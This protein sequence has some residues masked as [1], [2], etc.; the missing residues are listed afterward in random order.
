[1]SLCRSRFHKKR[2]KSDQNCNLEVNVSIGVF[3]NALRGENF[4]T[5]M[6]AFISKL[7][8]GNGSQ[9]FSGTT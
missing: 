1:M 6:N 3:S 9:D 4:V 2:L 5:T 7:H 8:F